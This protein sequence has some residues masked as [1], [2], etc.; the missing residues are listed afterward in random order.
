MS[1][2]LKVINTSHDVSHVF[3]GYCY[4]ANEAL[5][6]SKN[7]REFVNFLLAF[8][9][10]IQYKVTRSVVLHNNINTLKVL[11]VLD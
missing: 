4:Q 8:R 6:D 1:L 11:L 3:A 7:L 9:V 2:S 5:E 10:C